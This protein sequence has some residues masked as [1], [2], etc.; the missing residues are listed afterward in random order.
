VC[1]DVLNYSKDIK[2]NKNPRSMNDDIHKMFH[3]SCDIKAFSEGFYYFENH[4]LKKI[5]IYRSR[6]LSFPLNDE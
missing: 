4:Y 1:E 6:N 3:S 2:I 5:Y